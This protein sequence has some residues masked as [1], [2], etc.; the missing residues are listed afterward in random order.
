MESLSINCSCC[1]A[2]MSFTATDPTIT[3]E[4]CNNQF[5][6]PYYDETAPVPRVRKNISPDEVLAEVCSSNAIK[7]GDVSFGTPIT[8]GKRLSRAREYFHIPDEDNVYMIF[9][10]TIFGSCKKGFALCSSG[11]YY[12]TDDLG[13]LSW[14]DF[15]EANILFDTNTYVNDIEF[16]TGTETC[17]L[18]T[19]FLQELQDQL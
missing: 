15:F 13:F 12:C 2:P 4:Y 18:L 7:A 5:I 19:A 1:G 6:N 10:A 3:C 16:V 17:R 11:F 9:D 14:D 8:G